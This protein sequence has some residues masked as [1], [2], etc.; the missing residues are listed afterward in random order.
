MLRLD[1]LD[2]LTKKRKRVGRGGSRG[3]TSGRGEGGQK[4]RSGGKRGLVKFEGGQ[5]PLTRRIPRRG[6]VS[7]RSFEYELVNIGALEE[8]FAANQEIGREQLMAA[9]LIKGR[10]GTKVKMLGDGVLTKSLKISV[11]AAS[12]AA[13]EAVKK[14]GGTITL[15]GG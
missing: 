10:R 15:I 9:G 5:T 13:Q 8:K 11:D 14:A 7:V 6:F 2:P 12:E 3:G 4:R 1:R